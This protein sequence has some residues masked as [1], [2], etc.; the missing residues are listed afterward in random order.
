M[1]I[2]IVI[3]EMLD[4]TEIFIGTKTAEIEKETEIIAMGIGGSGMT[5]VCASSRLTLV[6]NGGGGGIGAPTDGGCA[7][8]CGMSQTSQYTSGSSV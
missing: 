3:L 8:H 1:I 4:E 7:G 2:A 6:A 5:C